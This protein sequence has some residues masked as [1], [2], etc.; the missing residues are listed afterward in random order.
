MDLNRNQFMQ[1]ATA[2][3]MLAA[4]K[5]RAVEN[6]EQSAKKNPDQLN[7]AL[8]G[9]GAQGR[10]LAES[11]VRIPGI[12]FK[13]VCDIWES[14][15]LRN[16]ARYIYSQLREM[17]NTYV[18]YKAMLAAETD[19]LDAVIVA[20]PDWMHADLMDARRYAAMAIWNGVP[21]VGGRVNVNYSKP[22]VRV[23][24]R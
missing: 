17:P 6:A 8:I 1:T 24:V 22:Q 10:I 13:A 18:D 9:A 4:L 20:S 11:C 3:M 15:N 12:R 19:G 23:R 21:T 5:A 2:G 16:T 14:Y 7:I